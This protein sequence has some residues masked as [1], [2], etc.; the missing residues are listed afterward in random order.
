MEGIRGRIASALGI[1][2][3]YY[4]AVDEPAFRGLIDGIG[5]L[6][7]EVEDEVVY[8]DRESDPPAEIH[9]RPGE[10]RLP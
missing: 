8:I 4:I 10:Q 3:P 5:G 2:L 7:L 6:T 9:V 1:D